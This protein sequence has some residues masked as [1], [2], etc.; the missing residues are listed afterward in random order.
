MGRLMRK[1]RYSS[2]QRDL[3]NI[4]AKDL[5]NKPG[6][7]LLYCLW[8]TAVL[9]LHDKHQDVLALVS[10]LIKFIWRHALT[11]HRDIWG[12]KKNPPDCSQRVKSECR[13]I[14]H[15]AR[16]ANIAQ[17]GGRCNKRFYFFQKSIQM[18]I[19][20]PGITS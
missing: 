16:L 1:H 14:A 15:L 5:A 9:L 4:K 18:N 8:E 6:G 20:L 12:R 2:V 11:A 7:H 19:S 17:V 3:L 10:E 13:S